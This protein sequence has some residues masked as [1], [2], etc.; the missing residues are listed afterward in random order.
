MK[1]FNPRSIATPVYNALKKLSEEGGE[2][3]LK[4]QK[5]QSFALYS[6]LAT[7]GMMRLKAEESALQTKKD[8]KS[9]RNG[10]TDIIKAYFNCLEELSGEAD[11]VGAKGLQTITAMGTE[12]YLGLT[13]LGL[14]LA[15]EFSFWATAIY[16]DVEITGNE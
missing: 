12:E 9:I 4:E 11:L 1:I 15:Q 2:K 5:S 10:K 16:V 14:T 7:W 3:D 6:Y 13:S 8:G